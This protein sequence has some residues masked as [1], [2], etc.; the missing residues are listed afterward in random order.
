M[1]LLGLGDNRN[2]IAKAQICEFD[3][4]TVVEDL[5]IRRDVDSLQHSE[6]VLHLD[7]LIYGV[8]VGHLAC[9]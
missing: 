1:F 2:G 8:D 5:E 9:D 7:H 6:R 3:G 4:F